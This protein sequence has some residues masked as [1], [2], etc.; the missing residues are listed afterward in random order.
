MEKIDSCLQCYEQK[1]YEEAYK[2]F[3]ECREESP[4]KQEFDYKYSFKFSGAIYNTVLKN[5]TSIDEKFQE[6]SK[7]ILKHTN[8]KNFYYQLTV[9]KIVEIMDKN[10]VDKSDKIIKWLRYLDYN[11]LSDEKV[12]YKKDGKTIEL[13]SQ[14]EKYFLK[15]TKAYEKV[16]DY[17]NLFKYSKLALENIENFTNNADVWIKRRIAICYKQKK[18]YA[19]AINE[20]L[21]IIKVK[22]E[23]FVYGELAELYDLTGEKEK[24]ITNYL[25]A[26]DKTFEPKMLRHFLKNMAN[27]LKKHGYDN[28]YDQIMIF[29][30]AIGEAE[31]KKHEF[32]DAELFEIYKERVEKQKNNNLKSQ[33]KTLK[34]NVGTLKYDFTERYKGEITNIS[35]RFFFVKTD[36]ERYFCNKKE[37]KFK[38]ELKEGIKV[39]FS[40]EPSFDK[41]KNKES[42]QAVDLRLDNAN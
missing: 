19:S 36:K 8:S 21:E 42:F 13:Y 11:L 32:E 10:F 20:Y 30:F 15:L 29:Y 1:N 39:E 12:K 3:K 27:C 5:A 22:K 26:L 17:E 37:W 9:L 40:L 14:R 7:Y 35:D 4:N 38:R 33:L 41:K 31:G 16:R 2:L 18:D 28:A 25:Q 6:E 23:W 34:N 24:S